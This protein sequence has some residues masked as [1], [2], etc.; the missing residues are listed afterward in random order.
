MTDANCPR[1]DRQQAPDAFICKHCG[2]TIRA[3]LLNIAQLITG[4]DEKRARV[5]SAWRHGTIGR[6]NER[7]LP[8]DPRVTD[9]I[10]P[11]TRWLAGWAKVIGEQRSA[12]PPT[13]DMST[14]LWVRE[15]VQWATMQEWAEDLAVGVERAHRRITAL[16]DIPPDREA[17]GACGAVLDDDGNT[18]KEILAAVKGDSTHT[19]PKCK[20]THDVKERRDHLL[21][22]SKELSVTVAEAVSLLRTTGERE[23]TPRLVRAVIRFVPIQ[24]TGQRTEVDRN[25][26]RRPPVDTYPLGAIRDGMDIYKNDPAARKRIKREATG[27]GDGN[28]VMLSA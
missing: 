14:I 21:E 4:A 12:T 3:Q 17:I 7:P 19:C 10:Q 20:T 23:A 8:Y 11:F 27:K 26:R 22:R 16:F 5:G 2:D 1:C 15:F 28:G 18:C 9:T 25:G 24:S 6:S 13:S